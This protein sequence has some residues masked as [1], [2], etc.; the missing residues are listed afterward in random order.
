VIELVKDWWYAHRFDR[1][2]QAGISWT[3]TVGYILI[4]GAS[5]TEAPVLLPLTRLSYHDQLLA[6][7]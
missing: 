1:G 2:K 3:H 4:P 6:Y 5:R 7:H